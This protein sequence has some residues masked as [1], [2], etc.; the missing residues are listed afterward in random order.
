MTGLGT[1]ATAGC[2]LE[3]GGTSDE[4][5]V[6]LENQTDT[7]HRLSVTVSFESSTLVDETVTLRRVAKREGD[8]SVAGSTL[9]RSVVSDPVAG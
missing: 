1:A 8:G 3:F 9:P 7:V 6:A 5:G 4:V 2:T